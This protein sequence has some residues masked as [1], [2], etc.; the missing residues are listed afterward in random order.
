LLVRF[1]FFLLL[2]MIF[3]W[4]LLQ[5]RTSDGDRFF[6]FGNA[7]RQSEVNINKNHRIEKG[8]NSYFCCVAGFVKVE[9]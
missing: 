5:R 9:R 7:S 1:L 6:S 3:V 8:Q 2:S 4:S